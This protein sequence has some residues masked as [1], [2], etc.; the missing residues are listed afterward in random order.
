MRG[1]LRGSD[2]Y[3]FRLSDY[4]WRRNATFRIRPKLAHADF[5]Y[6]DFTIGSGYISKQ[7][8]T[9]LGIPRVLLVATDTGSHLALEAAERAR[10]RTFPIWIAKTLGFSVALIQ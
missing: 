6:T 5:V 7:R 10:S 4:L 2:Y 9:A 3:Q 8:P 1:F